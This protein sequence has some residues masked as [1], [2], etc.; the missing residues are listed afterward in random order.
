MK[1][2]KFIRTFAIAV[3]AVSA[4]VIGPVQ[5]A[6][7]AEKVKISGFTWPGYGFWFIA[8]EKNLAPKLDIS[9]LTIED[10]YESYNLVTA[11]QMDVVSSTA[12]F[13]PIAAE[14]DMPMKLVAF[15]NLSYGTDKIV[16]APD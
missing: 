16:A 9:Y 1:V 3:M 8:K 2:R 5:N 15:A 11:N 6:S 12:E 7:A 10:P 13:A 14:R 4:M